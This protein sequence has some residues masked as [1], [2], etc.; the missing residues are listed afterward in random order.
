VVAH[1]LAE[2][3]LL[4]FRGLGLGLVFLY[5]DAQ[6]AITMACTDISSSSRPGKRY[7]ALERAIAPVARRERVRTVKCVEDSY[8]TYRNVGTVQFVTAAKEW[9]YHFQ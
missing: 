6:R 1:G 7:H 2:R 4:A 9:W 3:N 5:C 8:G